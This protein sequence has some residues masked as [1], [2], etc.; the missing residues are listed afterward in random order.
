VNS[1]TNHK[2]HN[3]FL[4]HTSQKSTKPHGIFM[5]TTATQQAAVSLS[6]HSS[7]QNNIRSILHEINIAKAID[8]WWSGEFLAS[9]QFLNDVTCD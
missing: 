8:R 6:H 4:F 9:P 3:T 7:L 1:L 5:N 2:Q